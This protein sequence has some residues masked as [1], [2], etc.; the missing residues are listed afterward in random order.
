MR[1]KHTIAATVIITFFSCDSYSEIDYVQV[2]EAVEFQS[3]ENEKEVNISL[4]NDK[5]AE[6]NETFELYLTGATGVIL[7][8]YPLTMVVITNEDHGKRIITPSLTA[9][10]VCSLISYC[11]KSYA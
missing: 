4:V 8:P 3:G 1:P 5:R 11:F 9:V 10:V 7:S 6:G 2:I